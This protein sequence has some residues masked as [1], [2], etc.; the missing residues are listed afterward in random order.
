MRWLKWLTLAWPGLPQLWFA[1]SWGALAMAAGFA[2]LLIA[3]ILTSGLWFELLSPG[4]QG[5][6]WT[7]V[8]VAWLVGAGTSV[9]WVAALR[10]ADMPPL[11]EDL[12]T[13]ARSEY[14]QGHWYEAEVLL[15]RLLDQN[16]LDAEARLLLA[17]LLRRT[18]RFPEA[19]EQL[20]RLSRMDGGQAWQFET[21]RHIAKI[22]QQQTE[23]K[24]G[25][26][27]D[28]SPPEPLVEVVDPLSQAA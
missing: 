3:A 16:V 10:P 26:A 25:S 11:G 28:D 2:W 19:S 27:A 15:G 18:K 23:Q 5:A 7:A 9:R 24:S 22:Q 8:G 17:S 6:L 13:K 1:G 21:N 14:L 4:A 20:K 12:F